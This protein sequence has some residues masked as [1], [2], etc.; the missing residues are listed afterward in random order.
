MSCRAGACS[1]LAQRTCPARMAKDLVRRAPRP[2]SRRITSIQRTAPSRCELLPRRSRPYL[3]PSPPTRPSPGSATPMAT[4]HHGRRPGGQPTGATSSAHRKQDIGKRREQGPAAGGGA[5]ASRAMR[6]PCGQPGL[7]AGAS[8]RPDWTCNQRWQ[9]RRPCK[10]VALSGGHWATTA[11]P[12]W[13]RRLPAGA[14]A[15]RRMGA[16]CRFLLGGVLGA[17]FSA[18]LR[19]AEAD[20]QALLALGWTSLARCRPAR[21]M[22]AAAKAASAGAGVALVARLVE[23]QRIAIPV[24]CRATAPHSQLS[25][26]SLLGPGPHVVRPRRGLWPCALPPPTSGCWATTVGTRP[27][28][29]TMRR[30]AN[31]SGP[32]WRWQLVG[33]N[34]QDPWFQAFDSIPLETVAAVGGTAA[35]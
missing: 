30:S 19:R 16:P 6:R 31:F 33:D 24:T 28:L 18:D 27:K 22:K 4:A 23:E 14:R 34:V 15:K 35:T 29:A 12:G 21:R 3:I 20:W 13:P 10:L 1:P 9:Q 32:A 2:F 5:Q 25:K 17:P 8:W 7:L 11:G 26:P